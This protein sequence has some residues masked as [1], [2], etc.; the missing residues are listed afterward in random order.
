MNKSQIKAELRRV[1]LNEVDPWHGASYRTRCDAREFVSDDQWLSTLSDDEL[2]T[3]YLLV[4][5]VL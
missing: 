2:R 4:A 3:F 5:E 1:A